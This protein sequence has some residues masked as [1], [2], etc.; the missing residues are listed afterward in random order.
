MSAFEAMS[1]PTPRRHAHRRAHRRRSRLPRPPPRMPAEGLHST[2]AD[3]AAVGEGPRWPCPSSLPPIA[4]ASRPADVRPRRTASGPRRRDGPRTPP[5]DWLLAQPP[6]GLH[7]NAS[8][9][10]ARPAPPIPPGARTADPPWPAGPARRHLP[11]PAPP[12]PLAPMPPGATGPTEPPGPR[13]RRP[14]PGRP[15]PP[16]P[17]GLPGRPARPGRL[18]PIPGLLPMPGR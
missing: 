5:D 6:A 16:T 9:P 1:E 18:A 11:G 3:R 14:P 10:P 8:R 17:P 7:R 15:G 2:A 12:I 13:C 4:G